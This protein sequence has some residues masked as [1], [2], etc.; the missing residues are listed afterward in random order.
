M[1]SDNYNIVIAISQ[2]V[3][4]NDVSSF[5]VQSQIDSFTNRCFQT[6]QNLGFLKQY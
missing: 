6:E 4:F 1:K 5:Y 3:P 2:K